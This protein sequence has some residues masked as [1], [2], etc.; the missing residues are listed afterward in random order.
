MVFHHILIVHKP[1]EMVG[2]S[3][4]GGKNDLKG[5]ELGKIVRRMFRSIDH[6][7]KLDSGNT[8][9]MTSPWFTAL[10]SVIVNNI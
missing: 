1:E 4:Q 5:S 3:F 9:K 10:G 7:G 2:D 6:V 8:N